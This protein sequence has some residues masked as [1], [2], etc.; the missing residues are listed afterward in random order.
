MTADDVAQVSETLGREDELLVRL[1]DKVETRQHALTYLRGLTSRIE[2]KSTEPIARALGDGRVSALQKF[3]NTATWRAEDVF[4]EVQGRFA[5][6]AAEPLTAVI[7]EHGF[8]KKGRASIGVDRQWNPT[9]ARHENCQI[10]AFLV[11]C[12]GGVRTLLA[13]SLHI[14]ESW[15][16]E[17]EPDRRR[18]ER[19][20]VPAGSRSRTRPGRVQPA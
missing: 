19:V 5:A 1:F 8:P 3:I 4:R 18:R 20:R 12:S 11:G 6:W 2:R 14:P 17:S 15:W 13:S 7:V 10:G 9:T 16:G